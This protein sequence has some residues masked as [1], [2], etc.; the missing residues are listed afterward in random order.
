[1]ARRYHTWPE[2]SDGGEPV[3]R[4][5]SARKATARERKV[6]EKGDF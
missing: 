6:Y 5:V 2:P 1:L 3:G 4:I